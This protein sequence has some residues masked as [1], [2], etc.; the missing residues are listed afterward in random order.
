MKQCLVCQSIR[1]FWGDVLKQGHLQQEVRMRR[2]Q[3]GCNASAR[4]L[5]FCDQAAAHMSRKYQRIHAK[6]SAEHNIDPRR[7]C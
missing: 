4:A 3:L 2:K 6:W 1:P 5:I 7:R